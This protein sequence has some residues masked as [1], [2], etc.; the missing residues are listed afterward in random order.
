[1]DLTKFQQP[2]R[3]E[4][5]FGANIARPQTDSEK[6]TRFIRLLDRQFPL[7]Y[8]FSFPSLAANA[9][10]DDQS[11]DELNPD[12]DHI[13]QAF[14]GVTPGVRLLVFHPLDVRQLRWDE[15]VTDI[16]EDAT[17]HLTSRESPY[18][19]PDFSIWISNERFPA[20]RVQ[21]ISHEAIVPRILWIAAKFTFEDV[22]DPD[23]LD[24]LNRKKIPSEPVTFGGEF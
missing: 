10:S 5:Y 22:T 9:K 7:K 8:P 20:L 24:K 12:E 23:L 11:F 1:M 2:G 6:R 4:R 19:D 16:D 15:R 17:A 3:Y 18:N 13:Y 21:N 14:L